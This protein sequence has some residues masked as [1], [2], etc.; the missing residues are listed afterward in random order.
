MEHDDSAS[1]VSAGG[2]TAAGPDEGERN[3]NFSASRAPDNPPSSAEAAS[4]ASCPT[5]TIPEGLC[6]PSLWQLFRFYFFMGMISY[7]G[8]AMLIWVQQLVVE[9]KKWLTEGEFVLG[10]SL[11]QALPG[12][13]SVQMAAWTGLRT[14]GFPGALVGFCAMVLPA[15]L[16]ITSLAWAYFYFQGLP[17]LLKVLPGLRLAIMA[18]LCNVAYVFARRY[19]KGWREA[20]IALIVFAVLMLGLHP[21]IIIISTGAAGIFLL[22]NRDAASNPFHLPQRP[23]APR[24]IWAGYALAG[25]IAFLLLCWLYK[26]LMGQF[27]G[28]TLRIAAVAFGGGAASLPIMQHEF[29]TIHHWLDL[30]IFL[31]SLVFGQ[32]TP[33]PRTVSAAFIGYAIGSVPGALIGAVAVFVP[34][35]II[36]L[37]AAPFCQKLLSMNAFYRAL[38]AVLCTLCPLQV[39][40]FLSFWRNTTF[41][42]LEAALFGVSLVA[43]RL[44]AS[45][46]TMVIACGAATAFLT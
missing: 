31:D 28:V 40:M 11:C 16:S 20:A 43:Y 34:S 35:F 36:L 4:A 8:S 12:G 25:T 26:P 24:L 32:V 3:G 9:K 15:F 23:H 22:T 42:V 2:A 10:L 18:L 21:T 30:Q 33:G 6:L 7:G 1:I 37:T 19:L 46:I 27:A 39:T 17:A 41:G 14:L 38:G 45:P 13:T 5:P 44:G 29:V